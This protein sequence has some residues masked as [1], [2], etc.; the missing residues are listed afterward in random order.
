MEDLSLNPLDLNFA[1]QI[2][3]TRY[4]DYD[5]RS[6]WIDHVCTGYTNTWTSLNLPT[7]HTWGAGTEIIIGLH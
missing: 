3:S 5:N 4:R 1:D 7:L 6:S 2:E